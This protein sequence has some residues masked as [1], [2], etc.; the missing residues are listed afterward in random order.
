MINMHED[1][2]IEAP[3]S[4]VERA[5]YN[6]WGNKVRSP[7]RY[8]AVNALPGSEELVDACS[9]HAYSRLHSLGKLRCEFWIEF[10][11]RD[12]SR[13]ADWKNQRIESN[14]L[15]SS[16]ESLR[17]LAQYQ[18]SERLPSCHNRTILQ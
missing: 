14:V 18:T 8:V 17:F 11:S 5:F 10:A 3:G 1:V 6:T 9:V 4:F 7:R 12:R 2:N 13:S 16:C 15:N